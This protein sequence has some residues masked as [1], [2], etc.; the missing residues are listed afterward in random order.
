MARIKKVVYV[1]AER[2]QGSACRAH[3]ADACACA[4]AYAHSLREKE[5]GVFK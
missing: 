3:E 2:K 1:G 5:R 4:D